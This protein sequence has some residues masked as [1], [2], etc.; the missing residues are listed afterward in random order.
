MSFKKKVAVF[1]ILCIFLLNTFVTKTY[2]NEN[3]S[4]RAKNAIVMDIETG[5]VLYE[6]KSK[7]KVQIAS[8]TKI[9]TAL[10][11]AENRFKTDLIKFSENAMKQPSTSVYKDAAFN[12]TKDD[13]LTADSVMKGLLMASG[14]DMAILIAENIAGDEVSFSYLMDKKAL[15]IGMTDSDF[16]TA[17]GLD[18]D[19]ILNGEN[20]YST[21]YDMALLGITAYNNP[22]VRENM[23]I[24]RATIGTSN[25][26][27]FSI[28]NSNKNLGKNNCIGGKTGYTTKAQRCLVAFY[29]KN[30]KNLVGVV[31]GGGNPSYFDDMNKIIDYASNI[32]PKASKK[33][34]DI[35]GSNSFSYKKYDIVSRL[36]DIEFP[37]VLREDVYVYDNEFNKKNTEYNVYKNNFS[38]WNIKDDSIV[39]TLEIREPNKISTYELYLGDETVEYINLCKSKML[40]FFYILII[41]TVSFIFLC[42]AKRFFFKNSKKHYFQ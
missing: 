8:T 11:L 13:Y 10:I 22:W 35:I 24:K 5:E 37:M 23:C 41:S 1:N 4:I 17:S 6:K 16:W 26:Y 31:L 15:E 12:L 18:T 20:H 25:G 36:F 21:A 33:K 28:E 29:Q 2:A 32:K 9:M 19:N 30:N 40:R 14:N 3:I 7:E 27:F 42:I 34:D 39:G 38:I